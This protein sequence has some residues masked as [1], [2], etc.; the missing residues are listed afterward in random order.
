M[1]PDTEAFSSFAYPP[2]LPVLTMCVARESMAFCVELCS[3]RASVLN[4]RIRD[5]SSKE[6]ARERKRERERER[7][8]RKR[9]KDRDRKQ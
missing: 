4:L 6:R 3:C 9:A 7:G 2:L 5:K 8:R 1:T